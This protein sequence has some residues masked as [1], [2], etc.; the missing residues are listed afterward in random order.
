[1]IPQ[2]TNE[3]AENLSTSERTA[4]LSRR[5]DDSRTIEVF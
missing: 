2:I 1:M 4:P 3:T 5:S